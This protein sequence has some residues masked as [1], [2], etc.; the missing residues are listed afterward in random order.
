MI[1]VPFNVCF[2]AGSAVR[3]E[4]QKSMRKEKPMDILF[5]CLMGIG[6]VF[7]GLI[8]L[9]ILCILMSAIIGNKGAAKD[10]APASPAPVQPAAPVQNDELSPEKRR[11][12]IAAV[13]AVLAEEL[14]KDVSAIRVISFKKI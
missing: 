7:L 10:E 9:I 12:M 8:C 6:I 13:S 4:Y 14:G 1:S 2:A 11:E 5:V 3:I